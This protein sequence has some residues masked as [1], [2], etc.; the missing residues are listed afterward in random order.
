LQPVKVLIA[1]IQKLLQ[2]CK[3]VL[4]QL[5]GDSVV[6]HAHLEDQRLLRVQRLN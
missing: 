3:L 4:H 1:Q 2:H 5:A 6:V